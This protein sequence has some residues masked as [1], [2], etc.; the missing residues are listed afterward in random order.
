LNRVAAEFGG[1]NVMLGLMARHHLHHPLTHDRLLG[2]NR[3]E[4][5]TLRRHMIDETLLSAVAHDL[6]HLHVQLGKG[7]AVSFLNGA[8]P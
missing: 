1:A 6:E 4:G 8:F 5:V 2:K 3:K 7:R